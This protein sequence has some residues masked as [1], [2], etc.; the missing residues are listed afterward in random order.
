MV[1]TAVN[2]VMSPEDKRSHTRAASKDGSISQVARTASAE[3][4]P[5]TM[6]CTWCSGNTSSR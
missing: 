5:L 6:P 3:A 4:S 2:T 1:G